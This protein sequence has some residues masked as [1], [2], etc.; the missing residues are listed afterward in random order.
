MPSMRVPVVG[1]VFAQP[2]IN[3]KLGDR[4]FVKEIPVFVIKGAA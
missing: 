2:V 3:G 4:I 1:R